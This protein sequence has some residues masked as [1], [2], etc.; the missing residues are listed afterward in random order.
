M[1][2]FLFHLAC[3]KKKSIM[4]LTFFV[5]LVRRI[6]DEICNMISLKVKLFAV[7]D[8][9]FDFNQMSHEVHTRVTMID[10]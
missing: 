8:I 4:M 1:T 6:E 2:D 5:L 10:T 3:G 7:I 9:L